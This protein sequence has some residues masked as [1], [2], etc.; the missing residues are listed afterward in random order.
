MSKLTTKNIKDMYNKSIKS[1]YKS[2]YEY[3]RWFS[4]RTSWED[5]RMTHETLNFHLS[6]L[7]IKNC[8]EVGSGA[9]TWTKLILKKND[10]ISMTLC[11]I[12]EA[13]IEQAKMNLG[14]KPNIKYFTEDFTLY[15]ETDNHDFFFSIRA[16]EYMPEK[17]KVINNIKKSL[18]KNGTG[19]IM[20]KNP[21]SIGRFVS[22]LFKKK[23]LAHTEQISAE[24]FK[25]KLKKA[26]FKSIKV[27]PAAVF[28]PPIKHIF[29]I[30]N[31]IWR[32]IYKKEMG[33]IGKLF[34]ESYII[35]FKK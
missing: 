32:Q 22:A 26:G 2:D 8:L 34:S 11:D 4:E 25:K 10:N 31:F 9:A 13:M 3:Y 16:I 21:L 23:N 30:G 12:S 20:M 28:F 6:N 35:T 15:N 14:N 24:D 7:K 1:N 19:L 5:Y 17:E 27:Y 18:K 29:F 33:F